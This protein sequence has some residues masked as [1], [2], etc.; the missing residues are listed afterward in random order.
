MS[1]IWGGTL[2]DNKV[3]P[4]IYV[5]F[6]PAALASGAYGAAPPATVVGHGL[7][8]RATRD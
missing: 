6:L 8:E 5:D 3:G 4:G 2:K 7:L 1:S